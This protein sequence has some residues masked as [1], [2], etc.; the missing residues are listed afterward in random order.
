MLASIGGSP[1]EVKIGRSTNP[2]ARLPEIHRSREKE[3]FAVTLLSTF[4][5]DDCIFLEKALHDSFKNINIKNEWFQYVDHLKS[6][7]E[8]I[9]NEEFSSNDDLLRSYYVVNSS[10]L[11]S[12]LDEIRLDKNKPLNPIDTNVSI[13]GNESHVPDQ[14]GTVNQNIPDCPHKEIISLYAKHLPMGI[15][16]R[17]WDGARAA[18]LKARWREKK[19]RQDLDWWERFF[20]HASESKFLTGQ[21]STKDR[22]AFEVTLPWMLKSE[23]FKKIIE[24]VYHR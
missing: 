16:P 14:H 13:V 5:T 24:G 20:K 11:R 23:N 17:E 9:N 4:K 18:T 8:S 21:V 10:Q 3:G 1:K 19:K 15:Q 2:W 12:P 7:S 22:P 6:L